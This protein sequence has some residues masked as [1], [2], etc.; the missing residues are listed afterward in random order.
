MTN[1]K[2]GFT[3]IELLV[4]IAI[5]GILSAIGLV[6]LNGARE[7]A[8]DSQ[9]KS[10]IAQMGTAMAL[11]FDDNS[12]QYPLQVNAA[13]ATSADCVKNVSGTATFYDKLIV[14]PFTE[15][16]QAGNNMWKTGGTVITAYLSRQLVPPAGG[17]GW[18]T[19]YCYDTNEAA[20]PARSSYSLFAGLENVAGG[21]AFEIRN[22]G[23][24]GT[25]IPAT[26]CSAQAT[27]P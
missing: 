17:T 4:V 12:N 15:A 19:T 25:T 1:N 14:T 3:L 16:A 5:I 11:F 18:M 27:C 2:K 24:T 26:A 23:T 9:R 6:S 21:A 8:R 20:T 22:D 13:P 10:D 7:K